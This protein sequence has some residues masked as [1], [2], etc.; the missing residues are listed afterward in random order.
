MRFDGRDYKTPAHL[1]KEATAGVNTPYSHAFL[2]YEGLIHSVL[3]LRLG[4]GARSP[5]KADSERRASADGFL[6][7]K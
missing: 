7:L 2:R 1:G 3:C 5:A 6:P 4:H